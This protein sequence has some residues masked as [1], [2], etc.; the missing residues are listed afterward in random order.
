MIFKKLG[1][2]IFDHLTRDRYKPFDIRE[3]RHM[4]VQTLQ[5][6]EYIHSC[7][8]THTDLKPENILFDC[9]TCVCVDKRFVLVSVSK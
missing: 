5:A 9:S 6:L 1:L 7:G 4:A 2:S 8:L 3:V